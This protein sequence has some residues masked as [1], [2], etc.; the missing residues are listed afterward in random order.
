MIKF[1]LGCLAACVALACAAAWHDM[2]ETLRADRIYA[3]ITI[4]K[5]TKAELDRKLG[6]ATAIS[7]DEGFEVWVYKDKEDS[8]RY[9][10]F[11]PVIGQSSLF[12]GTHKREVVVLFHPNGVVQRYRVHEAQS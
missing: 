10:R 3:S 8:G 11:I 5:T 2:N 9:T 12:A 1:T 6:Q 7:L 4:G